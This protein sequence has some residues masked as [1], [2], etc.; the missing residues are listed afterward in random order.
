M[1]KAHDLGLELPGDHVR[2]KEEAQLRARPSLWSV[3]PE[4]AVATVMCGDKGGPGTF[5]TP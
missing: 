5:D 1:L 2:W 4:T 3:T